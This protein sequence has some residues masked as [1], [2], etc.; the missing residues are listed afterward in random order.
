M[1]KISLTT[2]VALVCLLLVSFVS[3]PTTTDS[4]LDSNWK[5][6]TTETLYN[7]EYEITLT[8]YSNGYVSLKG[9]N[10]PTA[11]TYDIDADN[12]I[13]FDW[14][15]YESERGFVET[16]RTTSGKRI[17][18]ITAKGITFENTER[19]VVSRH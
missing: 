16:I 19:F 15:D 18:K 2:V 8:L 4:K 13:T 12:W 7:S 5:A 10:G 3:G 9:A 14:E 11:G 17:K 6:S 1:K